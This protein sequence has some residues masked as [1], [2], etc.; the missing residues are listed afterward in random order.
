[1]L[2]RKNQPSAKNQ[3]S[4]GMMIQRC[5]KWRQKRKQ[6]MDQARVAT[7]EI[8]RERL[9]QAA[10]HYGRIVN[11]EQSKIDST[12]DPKTPVDLPASDTVVT[13]AQEQA[14]ST[15]NVDDEENAF[16]MFLTT[17]N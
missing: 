15:E 1:M 14:E 8:E 3:S 7:D 4:V 17:L 13:D 10:E 5:H 6:Y 2:N 9:L 11:E 12:R 16:P